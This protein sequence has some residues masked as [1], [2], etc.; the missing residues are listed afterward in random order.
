MSTLR[1]SITVPPPADFASFSP[2]ELFKFYFQIGR[3]TEESFSNALQAFT[4][5]KLISTVTISKW[6]NKNVI[7]TRYSGAFLNLVE[8]LAE[9]DLAKRW[10]TAFETVW[11][12]HSSGRT[13]SKPPA[14]AASFSDAVCTQHRE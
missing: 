14:N 7:P 4:R 2:S 1:K 5:G 11:A 6:K 13:Q 9:P 12:L 8:S 10:T 3:W